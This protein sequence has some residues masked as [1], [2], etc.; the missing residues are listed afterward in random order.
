MIIYGARNK[1]LAKENIMEKCP[2]C[3]AQNSIDMHVFQ[4]YAHIFWVPVFP[5]GKK[6]VSQCDNCKQVL[7]TK[8][9]PAALKLDYENLKAQ[10]KTPL[11]MWSGTLLIGLLICS[12]AYGEAVKGS[13]SKKYI[14]HV[15]ANDLLEV[16]TSESHYTFYKVN[17]VAGDSVFLQANKQE[18]FM[19]SGIDKLG[20]DSTAFDEELYGLTTKQL[21]EKFEKE[22][23][24]NV[25][26]K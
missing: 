6:G 17:K 14:Q 23:I 7:T 8:Q 9:M 20:T 5:A 4:K 21:K 13:N 18:V 26:R 22:E 15:Q 11:W 3:Q 1:Q 24:L 16:K 12:I 10:T 19:E 2:H 25:L